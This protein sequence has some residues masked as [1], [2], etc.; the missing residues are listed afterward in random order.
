M[1]L[2]LRSLFDPA[3]KDVNLFRREH[4][5]CFCGRHVQVCVGRGHSLQQFTVI[6]IIGHNRSRAGFGG[7]HCSVSLIQT[8]SRGSMSIIGAVT[9]KTILRKYRLHIAIEV[10]IIRVADWQQ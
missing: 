7:L 3:A 5:P 2:V 4:F 6:R 9:L 1:S 10:N 8:Q